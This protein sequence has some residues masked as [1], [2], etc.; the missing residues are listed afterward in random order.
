MVSETLRFVSGTKW[1]VWET[2][3]LVKLT[4]RLVSRTKWRVL[5]TKCRVFET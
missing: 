5:E 2:L 4:R 3:D 1:S